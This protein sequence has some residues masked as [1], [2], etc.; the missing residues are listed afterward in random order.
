MENKGLFI[1]VAVLLGLLSVMSMVMIKDSR[2]DEQ[3]LS[4]KVA[5]QVLGQIDV[6]TAAE[7]SAGIVVPSAPE[8]KQLS[9]DKL[10]DLWKD[11]YGDEI[12]ELEDESYAVAEDELEN[13]D[14]KLLTRWLEANVE[15]FDELKSVDVD[16]YEINVIELGLDNDD[17]DKVA[18]VVFELE[19]RYTLS[20]GQ[21]TKFKKDV[22]VTALVNFDE[23]DYSDEYVELMFA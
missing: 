9:N 22:I 16:D 18:E 1:L 23:G 5:A 15:G 2:V 12:E 8:V 13:R 21:V 17:D 6:P 3:A 20:E 7:I 11:L 4:D 14:Y 19:A 10:N